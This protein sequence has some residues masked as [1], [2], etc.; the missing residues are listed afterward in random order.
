MTFTINGTDFSGYITKYGY[1]TAV[2]PVFAE[3]VQTLDGVEHT[4][5]I[6][7][8]GQLNITIR[9]LT[10]AEWYTLYNALS[11]GILTIV[12]SCIQ[13]N[14]DVMANMK[15]DEMSAEKVLQNASRTLYGN[16][17]LTFVEL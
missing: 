17:Q 11:Q 13:R 1:E 2:I 10:G 14:A 16:T 4:A 6:R 5:V 9:P 12:Y 15:L 7:Y 8:R 3:S